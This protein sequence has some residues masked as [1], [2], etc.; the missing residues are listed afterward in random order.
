MQFM[1][2]KRHR[3]LHLWQNITQ[4]SREA[5]GWPASDSCVENV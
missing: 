4:I 2:Y 1:A 3:C 5:I